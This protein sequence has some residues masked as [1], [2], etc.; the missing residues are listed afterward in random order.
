MN[1]MSI[2]LCMLVF[3]IGVECLRVNNPS[4]YAVK[5]IQIKKIEPMRQ[6]VYLRRIS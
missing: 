2:A 6:F 4:Y 1:N 3:N 5:E